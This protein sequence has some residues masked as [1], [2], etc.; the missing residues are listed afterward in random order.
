MKIIL[1]SEGTTDQVKTKDFCLWYFCRLMTTA[2]TLRL[3]NTYTQ[4]FRALFP[5][6]NFLF[7]S[8]G[9]WN[10]IQF[11]LFYTKVLVHRVRF[12]VSR[13]TGFLLHANW[14]SEIK[15]IF[16]EI[17]NQRAGSEVKKCKIIGE[18]TF[19]GG[20]SEIRCYYG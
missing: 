1:A 14:Y 9:F 5:F 8:C 19:N 2:L 10:R 15:S 11:I 13:C 4:V 12:L 17:S 7:T 16:F 20:H 18:N 3:P 6:C